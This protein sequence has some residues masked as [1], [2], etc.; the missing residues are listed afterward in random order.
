[1]QKDLL[2]S[3]YLNSFRGAPD[4]KIFPHP[5]CFAI[6]LNEVGFQVRAIEFIKYDFKPFSALHSFLARVGV[7]RKFSSYVGIYAIKQPNYQILSPKIIGNRGTHK[8]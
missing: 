5:V 3:Q 1:M 8:T 6:Y 2:D 7:T 4:H